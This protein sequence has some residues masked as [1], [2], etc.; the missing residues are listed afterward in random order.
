MKRLFVAVKIHPNDLLLDSYKMISQ[1]LASDSIKWVN[2]DNF[3]LT[4]KFLGDI[5]NKDVANIEVAL[6]EGL[7]KI[8]S[9]N[10]CIKGFGYFG[11]LRFPRVLWMGVE[12]S[13]GLRQA[14]A[15]VNK[16]LRNWGNSDEHLT[17]NPHLTLGRIK[18]CRN[19]DKILKLEARWIDTIFL[20]QNIVEI[21]LFESILKP[22]GP[23]YKPL[24]TIH[25]Q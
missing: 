4:L 21:I 16:V 8:Q 12:P 7:Q 1:T 9:F 24:N 10:M 15:Q 14:H 23:I 11:N 25:L 22:S 19:A 3:H 6:Q 20:Q 17:F 2:P 13:E 18:E 5:P